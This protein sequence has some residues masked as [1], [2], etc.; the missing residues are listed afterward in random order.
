MTDATT[1]EA[2]ELESLT[3]DNNRRLRELGELGLGVANLDSIKILTFIE[4]LLEDSGILAKAVLEFQTRIKTL[5]DA[6]EGPAIEAAEK[7]R[8]AK[9]QADIAAVLQGNVPEG[10]PGLPGAAPGGPVVSYRP[11]SNRRQRRH[12]NG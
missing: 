8:E 2:A 6:Q 3:A 7:M 4:A 12:P 5:L 1:G 11:N 10:F 9:R